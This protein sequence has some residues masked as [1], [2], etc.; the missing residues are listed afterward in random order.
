V[1]VYTT[2]NTRLEPFDDVR[3]RRALSYA[4]SREAVV[5]TAGGPLYA[6]AS[7]QVLPAN[8]PGYRPY[9]PHSRDLA[10]ARRLVAASGTRG[11]PVVVW[12]RR[13]YRQFYAHVVTALRKLGYPARMKVVEDLA[14]F[15]TLRK[16]GPDK[17]QASYA[18]WVTDY[19]SAGNFITSLLDY[20]KPVASFS[21][22]AVMRQIRRAQKLQQSDQTAANELWGRIDRMITDRAPV[23]PMYNLRGVTLVSERVGN[24]QYHPL[25]YTLLDQLWVR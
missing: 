18:G 20:L 24:F 7:C 9:C 13:S 10:E 16:A 1:A 3:V 11:T 25:W 23:V 6:S 8:F 19:P 22:R 15:D 21:D 5:K 2:L 12:T 14:Y 17:V 4:L